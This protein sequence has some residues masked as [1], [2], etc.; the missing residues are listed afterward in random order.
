L[1]KKLI[2]VALPLEAI[3]KESAREKSIR[4]G[5]PSTLHLWWAR[6]PLAA[7]RAVL[8]AS[9]VD[10]PGSRPDLYPTEE[11]QT[12]A[13][14]DLFQL[15]EKL[16]LWENSNNESVLKQA[17]D[18]IWQSAGPEGPPPIYDPFCG[19]G[20]IPLE[21][22]RLGLEAYGSDLNPVA[23]LITKALIEIPPKFS[24]QPPMNPKG[25][26][27][28][29]KPGMWKGAAGLA[30]DVRYY[31]DWMREKAWERIGHLYPKV[32][33]EDGSEATVV[34]WLWARTVTCPNPACGATMPL[35]HS[36]ALSTKKDRETWI[37]PVT[38]P[39]GKQ[40]RSS[41]ER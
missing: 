5:H 7:C 15:I 31:G 20:S 27:R 36:F 19:G 11:E 41:S 10:D 2:E 35:A 24:G 16:V 3:N 23:V 34:A 12:A 22:Q 28:A 18:A 6:R 26:S 39:G 21:A 13:R 29:S 9:L 30:E 33:L 32:K 1:K 14:Y 8:F 4:H 17:R 25:K 37:E 40:V 38:A